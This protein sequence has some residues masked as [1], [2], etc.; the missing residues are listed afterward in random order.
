MLS[1]NGASFIR[2]LSP[3][4]PPV[5]RRRHYGLDSSQERQQRPTRSVEGH[6]LHS[7]TDS[8]LARIDR[9]ASA[10]TDAASS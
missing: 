10:L 1:F 6:R 4:Y 7:L 2:A 8:K 9:L 3:A 5:I